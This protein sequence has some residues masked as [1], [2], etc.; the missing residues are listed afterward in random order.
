M[1]ADDGTIE[2]VGPDQDEGPARVL[3]SCLTG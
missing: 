2:D 3:I 1:H